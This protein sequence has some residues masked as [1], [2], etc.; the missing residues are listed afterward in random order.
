MNERTDRG[1]FEWLLRQVGVPRGDHQGVL[2]VLFRY[3]FEWFIEFDRNRAADGI[4]L[5]REYAF[6]NNGKDYT[7]SPGWFNVDCSMLEMLIALAKRMSIQTDISTDQC[8]WHLMR[9]IGLHENSS[10]T[11][12]VE[13]S[14]KI[15]SRSYNPDGTNGGL[16]PLEDPD[17]DQRQVEL[18]YQMYAYILEYEF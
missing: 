12:V 3:R 4:S 1:Y 9:N 14:D 8:F 18:L 5:R 10:H 17:K 7:F 11:E 13:A 6:E 15:V 16:F 2:G